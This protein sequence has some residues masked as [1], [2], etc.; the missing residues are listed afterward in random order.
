MRQQ[1]RRQQTRRVLLQG[2]KSVFAKRG[3]HGA[4]LREIASV[5]GVSTGA[6]YYNFPSKEELFL[7]LLDARMEERISEIKRT[8]AEES[9]GA[10]G[11][12]RSTLD[13]IENLKRNR[14]WIGLFFEFVAH[15]AREPT[16]AARF[17]A[18]FEEFW[19]A[20]AQLIEERARQQGIELPLPAHQVAVAIDVAGIGFMLPQI[21]NPDAV[22]DDLLGRM[23]AYMFRG[24]TLPNGGAAATPADQQAT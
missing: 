21:V 20:L 4:T 13:Y 6:L 22:P 16:F 15:A 14:E 7:A 5:A 8:L 3:Y 19:R 10:A 17:A 12:G 18:R 9:E 1:A 24:M 2:A 11:I 23:L